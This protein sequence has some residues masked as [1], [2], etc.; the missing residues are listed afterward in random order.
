MQLLKYGASAG[1]FWCIAVSDRFRH[2]DVS[3]GSAGGAIENCYRL[4]S[5][6]LQVFTTA[7]ARP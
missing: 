5:A 2:H 1:E 3:I 7:R 6:G 4:L